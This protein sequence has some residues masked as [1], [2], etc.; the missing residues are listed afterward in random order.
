VLN[1][2]RKHRHRLKAFKA[3]FDALSDRCVMNTGEGTGHDDLTRLPRK[4]TPREMV[5]EKDNCLQR[6]SNWVSAAFFRNHITGDV[7]RNSDVS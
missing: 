1:C 2:Y 6:I 7:Q 5:S 3:G 4:P